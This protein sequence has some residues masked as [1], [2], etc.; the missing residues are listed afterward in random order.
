MEWI[1]WVFS[2]IGVVVITGIIGL[3]SKKN[4]S[5]P[6]QTITSGNNSRNY[7]SGNNLIVKDRK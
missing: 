2:G 6:N 7:Q 4:K 1:Q 5:M 3:L